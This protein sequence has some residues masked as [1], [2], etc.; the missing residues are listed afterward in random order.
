MNEKWNSRAIDGR[1]MIA[2]WLIAAVFVLGLSL[3]PKRVPIGAEALN[4]LAP[5]AG[6]S[7]TILAQQRLAGLDHLGD[8]CGTCPAQDYADEKC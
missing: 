7:T 2:S 4:A 5:A 6:Q 3:E 8:D 1:A